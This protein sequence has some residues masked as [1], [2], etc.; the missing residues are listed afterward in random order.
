[1]EVYLV[2][3]AVRDQLLGLPVAERDWVVIGETPQGML[4]QGFRQVGR[5]FP[6]FLHPDTGEEYALART[7]RKSGTGHHG[8]E[9]HSDPSVTL[10]EDLRRRDLTINAIAQDTS[11]TLIDP[12]NGARD[13]EHGMLRHVSPAFVEDP[14]RVLRVARF[15]ARLAHLG[16]AVHPATLELMREIVVSGELDT[17]PAERIWSE[18]EK[19]LTAPSPVAFLSTLDDCG[20]LPLL[21]PD[22]D[23]YPTTIARLAAAGTTHDDAE[24][25]FALLFHETEPDLVRRICSQ[26]RPPKRFTALAVL[27][28]TLGHLLLRPLELSAAERLNIL[29]QADAL[30]RR[31]RFEK[32]LSACNALLPAGA[33][34]TEHWRRSLEACA[35][36]DTASLAASGLSGEA[37]GR[38][39]RELREA[40]LENRQ[41]SD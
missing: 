34:V 28:A 27:L 17:L 36:V 29:E 24:V 2:G 38:R 4:N 22:L 12:H 21:L 9:V 6:V 5:D 11:G 25:R 31:E 20:A 18:F 41:E 13:L 40:S 32:L 10:E 8:F 1:M 23:D 15:A 3:G 7:E 39:L 33:G 35:S 19:A 37:V 16:F 26:L 30:R 14:L